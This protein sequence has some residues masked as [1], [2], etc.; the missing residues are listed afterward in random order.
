MG[1][2]ATDNVTKGKCA[3]CKVVWYWPAG[4]R[5]LKDTNCPR[6][7]GILRPTTHLMKRFEWRKYS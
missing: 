6:C 5:R 1:Y 4:K 7:S 3:R 2:S